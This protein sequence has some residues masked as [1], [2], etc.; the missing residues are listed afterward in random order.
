MQAKREFRDRDGAQVAVLDALVDRHEEGMTV[1]GLRSRTDLDIDA[2]E[3]ALAELKEA[4]LIHVERERG[5][6]VIY[7]H[8]R[9]IPEANEEQEPSFLEWLRGKLPF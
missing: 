1:F 3:S 6:M 7:P 9:V 5:D 4:G 2:I 8:E